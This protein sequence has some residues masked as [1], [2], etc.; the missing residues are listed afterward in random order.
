MR[1]KGHVVLVLKVKPFSSKSGKSCRLSLFPFINRK[2]YF[3]RTLWCNGVDENLLFA[4][5]SES[6][7]KPSYKKKKTK[8]K[9][10]YSVCMYSLQASLSAMI[11]TINQRLSSA[12]LSCLSPPT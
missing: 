9:Q 4:T 1:H 3:N 6:N 7:M 11:V 10:N 12:P 5:V 2:G 8:T